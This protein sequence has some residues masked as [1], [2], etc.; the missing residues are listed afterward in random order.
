MNDLAFRGVDRSRRSDTYDEARDDLA[1]RGTMGA[2][3]YVLRGIAGLPGRKSVV[4]VSEGFDLGL[5]DNLK[6]LAWHA[7]T[8]VMD[9]ANRAGVVVYTVDP[10]GLQ[11]AGLTAE[12][13]VQTGNG[14]AGLTD[15]LAAAQ[16]ARRNELFESQDSLLYLAEQTG[17]FAV[18]NTNALV[19]G[20]IRVG[21]DLRGY[22]LIGVETSL[23]ADAPW[24]PDDL[25]LR[26]KRRGLEVRARRGLFGPADP[27][28]PAGPTPDDPLLIAAMS[29]FATGRVAL[30]LTAV[31]GHEATAG[32][33]LR[34]RLSI[35]PARIAFEA[36]PDGRRDADL[37]VLLLAV[38]D[39]GEQVAQTRWRVELRLMPEAYRMLLEEGLHYDAHLPIGK[40][41]GYQLRAAVLD[42]RSRDVGTGAQFVEIPKVGK[43]RLALSGIAVKAVGTGRRAGPSATPPPLAAGAGATPSVDPAGLV[44]E[45]GSEIVYAAEVYDGREGR[46]GEVLATRTTLL[47]DGRP[48]YTTPPAPVTGPAVAG[49]PVRTIPLGGRLTLGAAF[50]PG[51]YSLQVSVGQGPQAT[52][53]RQATQWVDFE[54]R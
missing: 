36:G 35:D 37:G 47:H 31:F 4:F 2:L 33:Y 1:S 5:R 9:D 53:G 26:V 8:R 54:V 49:Q 38:G 39:R 40:P 45:A 44:F 50:P 46:D 52:R 28:P 10:R 22:Y 34:S 11:G 19:D 21:D 25:R 48:L 3:Q 12:D 18:L 14:G 24:D 15:V 16:Q 23:D 6:S 41:G 30:A 51:T 43:G 42:E 7:F 20:L 29:P 27:A 13:V 32:P 17:G